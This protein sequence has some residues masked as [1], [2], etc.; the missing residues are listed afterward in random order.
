MVDF[1]CSIASVMNG[2]DHGEDGL[3]WV[4]DVD[5]EILSSSSML[6]RS[7]QLE[8]NVYLTIM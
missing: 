4:F 8:T 7:T 5:R 1:G 2:F 6:H 3:I